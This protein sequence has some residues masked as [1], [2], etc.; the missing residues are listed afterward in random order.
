[1]K[2]KKLTESKLSFKQYDVNK[3]KLTEN[4]SWNKEFDSELGRTVYDCGDIDGLHCYIFSE[5][6]DGDWGYTVFIKNGRKILRHKPFNQ[7][8]IDEVKAWAEKEMTEWDK[9]INSQPLKEELWNSSRVTD[10]VKYYLDRSNVPT[11]TLAQRIMKQMKEEGSKLPSN[12]TDFYDTLYKAIDDYNSQFDDDLEEVFDVDKVQKRIARVDEFDNGHVIHNDWTRM[13]SQE[14]EDK[15][16]QMSIENPDKVYYVKYDNVMEPCSDIKWKNGEQLTEDVQLKFVDDMKEA[17]LTVYNRHPGNFSETIENFVLSHGADLTV[18]NVFHNVSDEAVAELYNIVRNDIIKL[19]GPDYD[20]L[21]SEV[22][23][24][25]NLSEELNE[26]VAKDSL[27]ESFD[28]S[29]DFPYMFFYNC[30]N[31]TYGYDFQLYARSL[32][33]RKVYGRYKGTGSGTYFY[34]VP[35]EDVYNKLKAVAK[36]KYTIDMQPLLKYNA[37]DYP[38][39]QYIK[40]DFDMNN[41]FWTKEELLDFADNVCAHINETFNNSYDTQEIYL[42]NGVIELTVVDDEGT[43]FS[44]KYKPDMRKVK[45]PSHIDRFVL[46]VAADIIKQI[47][48]QETITEDLSGKYSDKFRALIREYSDSDSVI[49]LVDDI[50][51]YA[52]EDDLKDLFINRD[53]EKFMPEDDLSESLKEKLNLDKDG[54][55]LKRIISKLV[56]DSDEELKDFVMKVTQEVIDERNGKLDEDLDVRAN[57]N[58]VI[59]LAE[60]DIITWQSIAEA[61]L[62]YMSEVDV[63]DMARLYNWVEDDEDDDEAPYS[64]RK[65]TNEVTELAEEGVISWESIARAALRFMSEYDVTDMAS[66]Y[67]WVEDEDDDDLYE[68]FNEKDFLHKLDQFQTSITVKPED[69]KTVKNI[70]RNKNISFKIDDSKEDKLKF[71]LNYKALKEDFEGEPLKG[72]QEGPEAGMATLLNTAIQ[73]EFSTIQLYNDIAV[74]ARAEGFEDIANVID[75]INTDENTHVGQL[76]DLLKTISPNA[77]A[78]DDETQT[79]TESGNTTNSP[80]EWAEQ[81]HDINKLD[82]F[83]SDSLNDGTLTEEDLMKIAEESSTIEIDD[84]KRAINSYKNK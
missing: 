31:P 29:L 27:D 28:T 17:I 34:L 1:M 49:A 53:Y 6:D 15:A 26:D 44:T 10:L 32:G 59:E 30:N 54:K 20:E 35:S 83:V 14:A 4:Y 70:L 81:Y 19:Y 18:E 8:N 46:P 50:I 71:K 5:E 45:R 64:V 40:E 56:L 13:S 22:F 36:D 63:A 84:M 80:K 68:S 52:K 41:E 48:E 21:D 37:E 69:E 66:M 79:M 38:N 73:D 47:K 11:N 76:Q 3:K 43:E 25:F 9:A 23:D 75:A 16:R 57:T 24:L 7:I 77:A 61:C 39:F 60:E 51:R 62:M 65:V 58:K 78:I 72:P 67:S 33:A 82:D 2:I 74:T 42:T 55:A 12:T